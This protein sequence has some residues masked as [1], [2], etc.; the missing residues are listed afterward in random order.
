MIFVRTAGALA[1]TITLRPA[2]QLEHYTATGFNYEL[3]ESTDL[4]TW[5]AAPVGQAY[6]SGG[7]RV[8][9]IS[10][11]D[12]DWRVF[13]VASQPVTFNPRADLT[14]TDHPLPNGQGMTNRVA[15]LFRYRSA[16]FDPF[17]NSTTAT[18][19]LLGA[20]LY[21][22]HSG[23]TPDTLCFATEDNLCLTHPL[24]NALPD[25]AWLELSWE[26]ANEGGDFALVSGRAVLTALGTGPVPAWPGTVLFDETSP[27]RSSVPYSTSPQVVARCAVEE[28]GGVEVR[29][30]SVRLNDLVLDGILSPK[31]KI[32]PAIEVAWQ[33]TSPGLF[34]LE[35]C[36][37]QTNQPTEWYPLSGATP[38]DGA[39][40]YVLLSPPGSDPAIAHYRVAKL[41]DVTNDFYWFPAVLAGTNSTAH[42]TTVD[43]TR[44]PSDPATCNLTGQHNVWWSW[45]APQNGSVILTTQGSAF[46]ATLCV[47]ESFSFG[48]LHRV[49]G[50][51]GNGSPG[52]SQVTFEVWGGVTYL[53]EVDGAQ[54]ATGEIIL[55]LR[56]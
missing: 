39:P 42:G 1:D 54:G 10:S 45:T 56:M 44:D 53:I 50:D 30:L 20:S 29:S 38:N 49:A 2:F 28:W 9:L 52:S 24:T 34:R 47:Y 41:A 48:H 55:N 37:V 23:A 19:Q 13:R 15:A 7:R 16:L 26:V 33:P 51:Q 5:R 43:A 25:E 11:R 4:K 32:E 27:A 40:H 18:L 21:F 6:E 31:L 46:N 14:L 3:Q 17:G 12:A 8:S 22:Y 35:H 36:L